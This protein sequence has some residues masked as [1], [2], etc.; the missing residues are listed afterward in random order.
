MKSCDEKNEDKKHTHTHNAKN[1]ATYT[2]TQNSHNV[3]Q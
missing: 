2:H 3:I 1:K